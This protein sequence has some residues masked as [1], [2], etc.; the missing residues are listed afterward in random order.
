MSKIKRGGNT[1]STI[2]SAH[3]ATGNAL[4]KLGETPKFLIFRRQLLY[5]NNGLLQGLAGTVQNF[6]RLAQCVERINGKAAPFQ[7]FDV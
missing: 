3:N 5:F 1:S 4:Q 7:P 2:L 6:I